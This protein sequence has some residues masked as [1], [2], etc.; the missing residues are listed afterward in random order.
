[1]RAQTI[2]HICLILCFAFSSPS[3]YSQIEGGEDLS[4]KVRDSLALELAQI[5]GLDQ[6]YRNI[7]LK[8]G[9]P[10][11]MEQAMLRIDSVNL[12]KI[13]NFIKLY[14]Y[15]NRKLLG[16]Y[17]D[18]QS[19]RNVGLVVFLHNPKRLFDPKIYA[20][21]KQETLEGRLNPNTLIEFLDKYF[22]F[23]EK[24]TI[25]G[26]QFRNMLKDNRVRFQDKA[27]SDSLR[28]DIGLEPLSDSFF[29]KKTV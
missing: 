2:R 6:G 25:Y 5:Y 28:M 21:L 27:L 8:S 20:I 4:P 17:F 12:D 9:S 26:S 18:Q 19:I 29:I 11:D 23:F 13:M 16:N 22:V 3:L 1:M 14:G 24:R 15:P 7:Y 10:K